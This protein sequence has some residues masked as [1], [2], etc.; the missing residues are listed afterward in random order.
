[1]DKVLLVYQ[2]YQ[3]ADLRF[4]DQLFRSLCEPPEGIGI[5]YKATQTSCI[6]V[7]LCINAMQFLESDFDFLLSMDYDIFLNP[8]QNPNYKM[9]SDIK[10]IV[11]SVKETGG[12][13][14]GPYL[15]RGR[16][17]QLCVVPLEEGE[18]LI[19]PGGGLKEVRYVPTGFTC[20]SR[21]LLQDMA[22]SLPLVWFDDVTQIRPFFMPM[23]HDNDGRL[24][25]LTIDFAFSQRA[26]DIGYKVYLDTRIILGHMGQKMYAPHCQ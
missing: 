6:D 15:K 16:E 23:I 26:R 18:I 12:L 4:T 20:I 14:A 3:N 19:G 21:K 22:D 8:W 11:E 5:G 1:M 2:A 25:Y 17:D 7:G 24:E 9:G 10:R 13:V